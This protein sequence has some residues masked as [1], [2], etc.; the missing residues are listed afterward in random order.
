[1][2]DRGESQYNVSPVIVVLSQWVQRVSVQQSVPEY[3]YKQVVHSVV[4]VQED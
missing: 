2:R 1:M 3:C 4:G